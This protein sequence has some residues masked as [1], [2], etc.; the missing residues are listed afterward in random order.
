[1]NPPTCVITL[2]SQPDRW[3]RCFTHLNERGYWAQ[4][5]AGIDAEKMGL[6]TTNSHRVPDG[7]D[8]TPP[9]RH[10][11]C[12]LSHWMLWRDLW[13]NWGGSSNPVAVMEDDVELREDWEPMLYAALKDL[14]DD[15]DILFAGSCN[16]KFNG[17]THYKGNLWKC[18]TPL[19]SHFYLV[20]PKALPVLIE[21]CER[22]YTNIDWAIAEQALP[23]LNSFV[24]LPR[25][26]GQH[27][28][29]LIE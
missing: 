24:V 10:V 3:T 5:W 2:K 23:K 13:R 25:I 28:M 26:A 22:I 18:E 27:G 11:G 12:C 17:A 6:V 19:C 14:P 1:M 16:A 8:Y 9:P 7:R 20:R 15:W 29:E 21:S 4:P